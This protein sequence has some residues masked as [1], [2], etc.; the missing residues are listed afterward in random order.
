[1]AMYEQLTLGI[2]DSQ[3]GVGIRMKF[4]FSQIKRQFGI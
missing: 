4:F 3:V 2:P 1:M